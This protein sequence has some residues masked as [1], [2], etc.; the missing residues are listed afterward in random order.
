[1]RIHK[2]II[3]V[4]TLTILASGCS[5][6][7]PKNAQEF[8]QMLP[9]SM[10]GERETIEVNQQLTKVARNIKKKAHQ[11]EGKKVEHL[12]VLPIVTF[13]GLEGTIPRTETV[14]CL[15]PSGGKL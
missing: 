4:L 3:F 15:A 10:F 9:E 12:G 5:M 1:M 7:Y 11:S 13:G 2:R 8:R 14:S 6:K